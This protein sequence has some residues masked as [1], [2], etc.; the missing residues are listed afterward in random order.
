MRLL[1]ALLTALLL[2][3]SA[4]PAGAVASPSP[5]SAA[6]AAAPAARQDAVLFALYERRSFAP[7]WLGEHAAARRAALGV[8]LARE[9]RLDATV[10]PD[11]ERLL[12]TP[13]P[14]AE[15]EAELALSRAFTAYLARRA[16]GEPPASPGRIERA[17]AELEQVDTGSPLMIAM[18]ELRVVQALGGWRRV[19]TVLPPPPLGPPV[20]LVQAELLAY[21]DPRASGMPSYPT[22]LLPPPPPPRPVPVVS[23][24]RQRLVQSNDLP[25]ALVQGEQLDE[26]LL[27]AVRR[28]QKRN[29]LMVDGVVG[30]QTL[31]AL[32]EPVAAQIQ[33]VVLNLARA[34]SGHG[35]GPERERLARYVVVNVPAYELKLV[36]A[37]Q[38]TLRS[39]AIVGDEKNATPIFDDL[40][41]VVE[42]NPSW[43]VPRSIERELMQKFVHEPDYFERSGFVWRG[44]EHQ[45][46]GGPPPRL[47]QRPGPENA[48]GR[49]KF[50]FPNHHAVYI[51]DTPQRGLF[52]RSQR[53]LSHGCI[54]IEQPMDLALALLGRQGWDQG[55]IEAALE[56]ARTRRIELTR[57]IPVFL[58]YRTAFADEEGRLQLRPDIYGH[59]AAGTIT[60]KEKGRALA[61]LNPPTPPPLAPPPAVPR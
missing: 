8:L 41:R 24:L 60:F 50:L 27:Q 43:Y 23:E 36:D 3:V 51:H 22:E 19:T 21:D 29:G 13:E 11:L 10:T 53:S 4:L 52:G 40:I 18:A 17:L 6:L 44:G 20:P 12:R 54:R 14:P 55:R 39:R 37:G 28:F 33:K 58:D 48:L 25:A 15:A 61:A 32:N 46:E 49:F 1:L 34:R 45:H 57:P 59:D 47:V 9:A 56:T 5:L 2:G 7:L 42:I 26:P 16:G 38:V 35:T 30:P 31:G